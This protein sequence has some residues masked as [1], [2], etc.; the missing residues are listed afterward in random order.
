MSV[1]VGD[2]ERLSGV[3]IWQRAKDIP[4]IEPGRFYGGLVLATG[5][6]PSAPVPAAHPDIYF[7]DPNSGETVS[8][9]A[10]YQRYWSHHGPSPRREEPWLAEAYT[11]AVPSPR[12]GLFAGVIAALRS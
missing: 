2:F 3:Q 4:P 5:F 6:S 9:V 8:R 12:R 10:A 7:Q 11:A 1:S